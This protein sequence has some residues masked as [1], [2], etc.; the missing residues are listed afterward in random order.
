MSRIKNTK[1]HNTNS[2]EAVAPTLIQ[3]NGYTPPDIKE[4]RTDNYVLFGANNSFYSD[5]LE[6][7]KGSPTNGA[8]IKSYSNLIYGKGLISDNPEILRL[9]PKK[10]IRKVV[11]D[12]KL[13]G[14]AT[15]QVI[16][17]KGKGALRKAVSCYHIERQNVAPEKKD[18]KGNIN[19]F[20]YSEDWKQAEYFPAFG[21]S[22]NAPIEI[23]EIKPYT[24]GNSYFA[25][26][27]YVQCYNYAILEEE[28]SIFSVS[29]I[30]NG[31]SAGFGI[32]FVNGIPP[33]GE[34]RNI[35]NQVISTTT[36]SKNAARIMVGFYNNKEEAPVIQAFPTNESHK[37]WDFWAN[38]SKRQIMVSHR[39]TNPILFGIKDNQGFGS[40]SEEMETGFELLY[41]TVIIPMQNEILEAFQ[42]VAEINNLTGTLDF[43]RLITFKKS[44]N[45]E[46]SKK[47]DPL[48]KLLIEKGEVE[49]LKNW[50]LVD[51]VRV[52]NS[53][54][55]NLSVVGSNPSKKSIQDNPLFKVRYSYAPLTVSPNSRQFCKDMV[56]ANK[57]YRKEDIEAAGQLA[58]NKGLGPKGADTYSIWLYHGGARCKHFWQRKIYI[59]TN[60]TQI[61]VNEAQKMIQDLDPKDRKLFRF[62]INETEVAK[63]TTDQPN[64][65]YL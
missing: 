7:Y 49:D 35:T 47:K 46:L 52:D 43:E 54:E 36:G 20:Y 39:V 2:V 23:M 9:F 42:E 16:Y 5:V 22:K 26:P 62:P 58:V 63:R 29:H 1:R 41:G 53:E 61:S 55:I 44:S 37:Q 56:A 38:E 21:T 10:E 17:S 33:E 11:L 50:T 13:Y 12:F 60:N 30:K 8:V 19:G 3:L 32:S 59:K 25:H 28:I 51:N 64:H 6:R 14:S 34:R 27:D 15:F 24:A 4:S 31:L 65:G 45:L 18:S 57:T 48:A 40:N